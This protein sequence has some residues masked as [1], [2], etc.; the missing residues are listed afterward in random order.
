MPKKLLVY[1][2]RFHGEFE[3]AA[4]FGWDVGAPTFSWPTLIANKDKEIDR[5]EK[6]YQSTLDR[7]KVETYRTR[8]RLA[9]PQQ[10]QLADGRSVRAK[11]IL[12]ATGGRPRA[13]AFPG[14]DLTISSNEAFHL[15]TLPARI[16]IVGGGYI[17]L[18]FAGIFAGL[19]SDVTVVYRGAEVLRGFDN[20]LRDDLTAA[21]MKRGVKIVTGANIASVAR[22]SSGL[23]ATLTTGAVLD[24][25]QVM[26]AIGRTP[27]VDD[28]G[29]DVVGVTTSKDGAI[30]VDAQLAYQCGEHFR[31]R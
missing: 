4:G 15:K 2:S 22:D 12:V 28:L 23:R 5:L 11:T 8:A 29:L 6:A 1:A 16:V 30:R 27:N 17:A 9:G 3:D 19:G 18:E 10:V 24:A 7:W 14:A 20:D 13:G 21:M 26:L 25:D 31:G